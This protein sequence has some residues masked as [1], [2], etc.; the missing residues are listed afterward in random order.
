M[1]VVVD[2]TESEAENERLQRWKE[3]LNGPNLCLQKR[4]KTEEYGLRSRSAMLIKNG[5]EAVSPLQR[6]CF[7]L[8]LRTNSILADQTRPSVC[9]SAEVQSKALG[10]LPSALCP[11]VPLELS[12]SLLSTSETWS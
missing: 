8:V 5:P 9:S 3:V 6:L 2:V 10:G 1:S 12:C 4:K 7:A 11:T